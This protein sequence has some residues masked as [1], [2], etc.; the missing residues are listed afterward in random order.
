M[1]DS[2]VTQAATQKQPYQISYLYH[3]NIYLQN[4]LKTDFT[5]TNNSPPRQG[6]QTD[7]GLIS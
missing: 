7:P 3:H 5:T 4:S 1:V 2:A 6:S